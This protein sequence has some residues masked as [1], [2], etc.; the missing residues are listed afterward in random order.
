[1][2]GLIGTTSRYAGSL[3]DV[4]FYDGTELTP[5]QIQ[6]LFAAG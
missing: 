1:M 4:A 5:A 2:D 3:S 6:T